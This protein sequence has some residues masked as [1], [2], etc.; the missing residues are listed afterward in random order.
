MNLVII[1]LKTTLNW[2]YRRKLEAGFDFCK[3]NDSSIQYGGFR[4]KDGLGPFRFCG[5]RD[6]YFFFTFTYKLQDIMR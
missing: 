1:A 2:K 6:K 3:K 4:K 5:T